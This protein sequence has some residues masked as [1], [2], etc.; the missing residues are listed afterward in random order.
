MSRTACGSD[1]A[2]V[3]DWVPTLSKAS[4]ARATDSGLKSMPVGDA[5]T[6]NLASC[7]RRAMLSAKHDPSDSRRLP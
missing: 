7:M 1:V 5:V 6:R 2:V 4:M 3:S